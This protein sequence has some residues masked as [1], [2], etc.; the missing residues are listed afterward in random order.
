LRVERTQVVGQPRV[1]VGER[2]AESLELVRGFVEPR[3]ANQ[4]AN[5]FDPRRCVVAGRRAR[6]GGFASGG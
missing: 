3:R 4:R 2:R 1:G 5:A 6:G